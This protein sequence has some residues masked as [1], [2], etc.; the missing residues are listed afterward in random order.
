MIFGGSVVSLG[1][2]KL[3]VVVEIGVV[4]DIDLSYVFRLDVL[5]KS[6]RIEE[7]EVIRTFAIK[8][9]HTRGVLRDRNGDTFDFIAF[10]RTMD[11]HSV[12][13]IAAQPQIN[14]YYDEKRRQL[15]IVDA[16][17]IG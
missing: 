16:R 4:V 12:W 8:P 15:Q 6:A 10:N 5:L 2:H 17:C 11:V 14:E 9:G 3:G 7:A 13:N 1:V